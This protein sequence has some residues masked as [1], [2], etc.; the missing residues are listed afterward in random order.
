MSALRVPVVCSY[1]VLATSALSVFDCSTNM[2]GVRILDADPAIRCNEVNVGSRLS[3]LIAS[4]V[5]KSVWV[6]L[7]VC[8]CAPAVFLRLVVCS[9]D[10]S[11]LPSCR[12]WC[13]LW[14]YR[15]YL[16]VSCTGT[17]TLFKSVKKPATQACGLS[18][19]K[20]TRG[21]KRCTTH[22]DLAYAGG[23][24]CCWLGSSSL[25]QWPCCSAPTLCSRP[26]TEV[27]TMP[28]HIPSVSHPAHESLM[29]LG[30]HGA[31]AA[32]DS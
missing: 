8:T 4:R 5:S 27:F 7:T 25:R 32:L 30:V 19:T 29:G 26:G 17:A 14:G 23:A 12:C 13:T 15:S 3:T 16:H 1:I 11:H 31:A 9:P 21:T 6:V 18:P 22:T 28:T 10:S 20:W 24:W 2:D